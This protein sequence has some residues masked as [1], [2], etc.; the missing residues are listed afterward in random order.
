MLMC[1]FSYLGKC[2]YYYS[3]RRSKASRVW[4]SEFCTPGRVAEILEGKWGKDPI[5]E[6]FGFWALVSISET[7]FYISAH[8]LAH[9]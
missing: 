1:A 2:Q 3:G 5:S 4:G 7:Y 6:V 9:L 8:V